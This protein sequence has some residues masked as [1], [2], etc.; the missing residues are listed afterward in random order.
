MSDA[1]SRSEKA[2]DAYQE[3]LSALPEGRSYRDSRVLARMTINCL[4]RDVAAYAEHHGI[5]LDPEPIAVLA[6]VH[7]RTGAVEPGRS[8]AGYWLVDGAVETIPRSAA[9]PPTRGYIAAIHHTDNGA[10]EYTVRFPGVPEQIR[11]P[12][13]C[14]RATKPFPGVVTSRGDVTRPSEA[15]HRLVTAWA[16]T[17][18]EQEGPRPG[19]VADRTVIAIALAQWAGVPAERVAEALKD[20]I[21]RAAAEQALSS[22]GSD[23]TRLAASDLP[24]RPA[25][26]KGT[27]RP[28]R[29]RPHRPQSP[30]R[31]PR[32]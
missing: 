19:D 28:A 7:A 11:L 30:A 25:S 8:S 20:R 15:E 23:A 17:L 24:E 14:L 13:T 18:Q 21:L 22:P 10:L 1:I 31:D 32:P 3:A 16:R 9:L 27:P 5:T 29:P 2:L 26:Q 6:Q 4:L 12:G